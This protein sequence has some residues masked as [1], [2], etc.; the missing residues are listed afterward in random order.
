MSDEALTS[1]EV[2]HA[3]EQLRA[4]DRVWVMVRVL[5]MLS[6][7]YLRNII[8]AAAQAHR[9]RTARRP[10]YSR[11]AAR[12]TERLTDEALQRLAVLLNDEDNQHV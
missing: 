7:E 2:L 10:A 5:D 9:K 1:R 12:E 8:R 6:T 3:W 11:A 4:G